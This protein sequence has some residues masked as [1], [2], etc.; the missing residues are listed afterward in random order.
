MREPALGPVAPYLVEPD[1]L[2]P[3]PPGQPAHPEPVARH[4]RS[5][6]V[7]EL[8]AGDLR[9]LA[10]AEAVVAHRPPFAS[11]EY[12]EPPRAR[13]RAVGEPQVAEARRGQHRLRQRASQRAFRVSRVVDESHFDGDALAD[14]EFCGCPGRLGRVGDWSVDHRTGCLELANPTVALL[15]WDPVRVADPAHVGVQGLSLPGLSRETRLSPWRPCSLLSVSRSSPVGRGTLLLRSRT[16]LARRFP[17]WMGGTRL[18][19]KRSSDR[20][21][22]RASG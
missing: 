11:A 9:R 20:S 1:L 12:L 21:C 17:E 18:L 4:F 15:V 16:C 13:V 5:G 8:P 2:T 6:D 3:G 7:P 22:R 14:E 19:P 10:V